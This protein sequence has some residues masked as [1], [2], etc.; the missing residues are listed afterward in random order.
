[1]S[2]KNTLPIRS[3]DDPNIQLDANVLPD[4]DAVLILRDTTNRTEIPFR[5][6][7]GSQPFEQTDIYTAANRLVKEIVKYNTNKNQ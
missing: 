6:C 1:M 7:L 4:G 5:V 2:P 3:G